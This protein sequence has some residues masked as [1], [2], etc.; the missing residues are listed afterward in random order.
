VLKSD[1]VLGPV[2]NTFVT[3]DDDDKD[4]YDPTWSMCPWMK[5]SPFPSESDWIT[6]SQHT[7]PMVV[8]IQV[9]V[10]G[11]LVD[12]LMDYWALVRA[13]IF[14]Q[15]VAAANAVETILMNSAGGRINKP[16]IQLSGYG[17]SVEDSGLRMLIADGTI[18][19]GMF[20][21]T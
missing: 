7:S 14:P 20:L 3:W 6:E 2:T 18:R 16:T 17:F 5:I 13:A 21:Q 12:N 15:T 19:F 8:R 11:T 1:P 10:Q 9:A 4:L